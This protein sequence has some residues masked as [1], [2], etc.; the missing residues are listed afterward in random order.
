MIAGNM[1]REKAGEW[2]GL[3][4]S[5]TPALSVPACLLPRDA[6]YRLEKELVG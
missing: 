1:C 2:G 4:A 5:C 3:L 6:L